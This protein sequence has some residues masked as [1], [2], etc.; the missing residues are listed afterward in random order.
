MVGPFG[1]EDQ[2]GGEVVDYY[3]RGLT[4]ELGFGM[5]VFVVDLPVGMISAS[6]SL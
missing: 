3:V 6:R 1:V 4:S 5:Y 2:A